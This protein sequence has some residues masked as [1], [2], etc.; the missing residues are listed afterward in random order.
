MKTKAGDEVLV[1]VEFP[2]SEGLVSYLCR[3]LSLCGFNHF[4]WF[5]QV[6]PLWIGP[7]IAYI[8]EET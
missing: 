2:T 4:V 1:D 8:G 7:V 5:R 3:D 6:L